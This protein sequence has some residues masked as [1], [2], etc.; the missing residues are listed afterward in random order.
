MALAR[1]VKIEK[2][3]TLPGYDF[4]ELA[5]FEDKQCIINKYELLEG[6][7]AVYIEPGSYCPYDLNFMFLK[8]KRI[9]KINMCKT[10]SDGLL[11][12]ATDLNLTIMLNSVGEVLNI[13]GYV[14][15]DDVTKVL[16]ITAEPQPKP[17]LET[18]QVNDTTNTEEVVKSSKLSNIKKFI[19]KLFK[20]N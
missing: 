15:G 14:A 1:V 20:R 17:N 9:K 16:G 8:R 19:N 12:S 2:I 4:V 3:E 10:F 18:Q 5:R 11:M 7:L 6:D 13:G